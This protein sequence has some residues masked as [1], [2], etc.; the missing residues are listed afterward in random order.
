[1]DQ[2][3]RQMLDLYQ[4][5]VSLAEVGVSVGRSRSNVN[6]RLKDMRIP[7][8][9][10]GPLR[11]YSLREDFFR[12]I[13][14][15][16]KAYWL[17]FIGAD[18]GLNRSKR[19]TAGRIVLNLGKKDKGHLELIRS[20]L[21]YGGPLSFHKGKRDGTYRLAISSVKMF[22]DLGCHGIYPRK[23]FTL[24]GPTTLPSN[25]V[26]HWVRGYFDGDGTVFIHNYSGRLRTKIITASEEL[27]YWFKSYLGFGYVSKRTNHNTYLFCCNPKLIYTYMYLDATLFLL[28]KKQIFDNFYSGGGSNGSR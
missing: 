10:V 12:I 21:G 1:M 19:G 6:K 9:R 18:G 8:R 16:E 23:T 5:G 27:A 22:N 13:D 14:T 24:K 28:R 17:G 7:M 11:R 4:S 3:T 15:E 2:L 20:T 25:L 26:H